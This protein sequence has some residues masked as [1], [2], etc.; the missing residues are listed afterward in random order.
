[1]TEELANGLGQAAAEP[2][3]D[4]PAEESGAL[5]QTAGQAAPEPDPVGGQAEVNGRA[6][7]SWGG[8]P[9]PPNFDELPEHQ[10][11]AYKEAN[12]YYQTAFNNL[13][14]QRKQ[15][16][17]KYRQDAQMFNQLTR[18]EGLLDTVYS[19]LKSRWGGGQQAQAQ[20]QTA[21]SAPQLPENLYEMT[22]QQLNEVI[23]ARA[24]RIA[25]STQEK[26]SEIE[27][28]VQQQALVNEFLQFEKTYSDARKYVSDIDRLMARGY[29]M[30]HAYLAAKA[31][32]REQVL[33]T[34]NT[35][36][37]PVTPANA[38]TLPPDQTV[39]TPSTQTQEVTSGEAEDFKGK[40]TAEIARAMA[41]KDPELKKSWEILEQNKR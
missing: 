20:T 34:G 17:E 24:Q 13:S 12:A 6:E 36:L 19:D 38:G 22:P 14:E 9:L 30:K 11:S 5:D 16:V 41:E 40:S 1:M 15:E 3:T 25:S 18:D 29:S 32:E 10:Q 27:S 28:K 8:M 37:P 31:E 21:D 23:E 7:G 26:L 33:G 2:G 39:T 35:N 4:P